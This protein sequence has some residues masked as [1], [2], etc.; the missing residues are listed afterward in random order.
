[1]TKFIL[2]QILEV[3]IAKTNGLL[4]RLT[5]ENSLNRINPQTATA[6]FYMRHIA[7][8]QIQLCKLFFGTEASLPYGRPFTLGVSSDDGRLYDLTETQQ[9]M[10]LGYETLRNVVQ[11]TPVESWNDIKETK[12]FGTLTLIQGFSKILNHNAH[13]IGQI[14]LCFKKGA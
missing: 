11:Q 9:L 14:E 3:N 2:N 12:I 5:A 1:M 4:A 13:H 8:A 10:N 7:E 6:G